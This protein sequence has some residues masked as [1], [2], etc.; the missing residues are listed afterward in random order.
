MHEDS[1][2]KSLLS[3]R[4]VSALEGKVALI[5]IHQGGQSGL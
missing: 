1:Q 4:F 3:G 5:A 2:V